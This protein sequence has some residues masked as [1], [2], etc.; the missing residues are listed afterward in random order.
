MDNKTFTDETSSFRLK[1]IALNRTFAGMD[2]LLY[3]ASHLALNAEIASAKL[4]AEGLPFGVA[5]KELHTLSVNLKDVIGMVKVEFSGIALAVAKWLSEERKASLYL[6]TLDK[7]VQLSGV[8]QSG[9]PEGLVDHFIKQEGTC[10][11]LVWTG[12]IV[13]KERI[14]LHLERIESIM[15]RLNSLVDRVNNV[16]VKQ[17]HFIAVSSMIES[18]QVDGGKGDISTVAHN[19]RQLSREI[20]AIEAVAKGE[21]STL[22]GM[23]SRQKG[24]IKKSS[25]A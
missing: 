21:V 17:S 23:I 4:G 14:G 8:D 7:L 10:H 25:K 2:P 19:I 3:R 12:S 6:K 9:D 22:S 16:A 18:V 1:A 11:N 20:A 5:V 13:A 24:I 15:G